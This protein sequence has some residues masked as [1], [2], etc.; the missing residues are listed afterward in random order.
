MRLLGASGAG[1]GAGDRVRVLVVDDSHDNRELAAA[2][3]EASGFAVLTAGNGLEGVIVAHYARPAVIVMDIM[4][5]VLDGI[6]AARL[7]RASTVTQDL[8]LV[9]YTAK[10]RFEDGSLTHVFSEVV[11]KPSSPDAL[12][13][14]VRRLAER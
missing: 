11:R 10:P 5:P 4:M 6:E 7:L 3:L 2:V 8:P 13:D 12:A 1:N 9:A 14:V